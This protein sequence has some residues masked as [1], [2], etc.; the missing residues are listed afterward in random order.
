MTKKNGTVI[1]RCKYYQ[2]DG[3]KCHSSGTIQKRSN[4][5]EK[6]DSS[7]GRIV[8]LNCTKII[9]NLQSRYYYYFDTNDK[10]R[11]VCHAT[12]Y[13]LECLSNAKI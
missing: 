11:I 6:N 2:T 9:Q 10:D 1:Y 3:V 4:G 7:T 5:V 8:L 12:D 13:Q